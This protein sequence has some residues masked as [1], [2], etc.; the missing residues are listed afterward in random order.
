M[1]PD[2]LKTLSNYM[3]PFTFSLRKIIVIETLCQPY[4]LLRAVEK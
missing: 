4:S 1:Q 2:K 3:A